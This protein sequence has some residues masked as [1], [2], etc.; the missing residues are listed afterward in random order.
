M[1]ETILGTASTRGIG[2]ELVRQYAPAGCQVHACCRAPKRA[3][4]LH[5]LAAANQKIHLHQ[6]DV[7]DHGRMTSLGRELEGKPIDLLFN[8]AGVYGQDDAEFGNTDENL[9]LRAMRINVIAPMKMM[10]TFI[11]HVAS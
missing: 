8:N 3:T 9:W 4:A 7:T 5:T 2:L 6:L 1:T 11:G 10:E